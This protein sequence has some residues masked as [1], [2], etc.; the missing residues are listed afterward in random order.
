M[1]PAVY[2]AIEF[3][4]KTW[5][6][7]MPGASWEDA[8][9][10]ADAD[11]T[12]SEQIAI[13]NADI[14]RIL[15]ADMPGLTSEKESFEP[16]DY[17]DEALSQEAVLRRYH[18]SRMLSCDWRGGVMEIRIFDRAMDIGVQMVNFS[19]AEL[20]ALASDLRNLLAWVERV[21]GMQ[22]WH[23]EAQRVEDIDAAVLRLMATREPSLQR[24][25]RAMGRE[26]MKRWL[27]WPGLFLTGLLAFALTIGIA[28]DAVRQGEVLSSMREGVTETFVTDWLPPPEYRL[29]VF[30]TF[31]LVGHIEGQTRQRELPVFRDEFLRAG[32]G[33][34]FTVMPT[35]N[36]RQSYMLRSEY[37]SSLPLIRLDPV[38]LPWRV[39]LALLPVALWYF[40]FIQP[41]IK[42][43][44]EQRAV[45]M[46][47]V[48]ARSGTVL[49]GGLALVGVLLLKRFL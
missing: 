5:A 30:P 25:F 40:F 21:S 34:L 6:E 27:A 44:P 35:N 16:Y 22:P 10:I 42:T 14:A 17:E 31:V 20:P 32:P 23:A 4:D 26:R 28:V 47:R 36:M 18:R 3:I 13:R 12:L 38:V 2:F 33:A 29:G 39:I 1:S 48:G 15:A 45:K 49:L 11:D 7:S 9:W 24:Y 46:A 8:M 19:R 41:L 43:M 37:A